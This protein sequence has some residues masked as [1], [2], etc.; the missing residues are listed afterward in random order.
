MP[1]DEER[2]WRQVGEEEVVYNGWLKVLRRRYQ[3]PDGRTADW[4]MHAGGSTAA[5]LALTPDQRLVMVR[6]FRPGPGRV[7]LTLQG[8]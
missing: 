5:V 7:V 4:D 6:Q 3:L 2:I 8:V 1:S